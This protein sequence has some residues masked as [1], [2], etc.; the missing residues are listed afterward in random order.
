MIKKFGSKI[1]IVAFFVVII[2]GSAFLTQGIVDASTNDESIIG[3]QVATADQMAAYALSENPSP[4]INCTM[5]ELAKLFLA[6]GA[7]EGVRGDVAF[8]QACKETGHFAYGGRA[9]PEWNN[10]SGFGVTGA[11]YDPGSC[12]ENQFATGVTVI[13]SSDGSSVGVKFSEP[14]LGVRALIQHLKGY[15]TSEPLKQA[16]V[17]PRYSLI[18][19]GIAPNWVDLNGRWAVPGTN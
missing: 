5:L 14:R 3:A 10:Y 12:T 8:A 9:F 18:S 1:R 19:K 16:L 13:K 15:A 7:I 11:A 17:D 2:F 4:K 6:E